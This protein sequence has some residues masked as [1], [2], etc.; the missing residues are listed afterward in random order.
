MR[1]QLVKNNDKKTITGKVV[2]VAMPG[3][4]LVNDSSG[5]T[6]RVASNELYRKV[7]QVRIVGDQIV[8]TAGTVKNPSVY[9]V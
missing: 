3:W 9:E 5:H 8:G 4:Y 1:L 7:E 6:Y 2:K